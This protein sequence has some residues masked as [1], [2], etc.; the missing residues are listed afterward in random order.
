MYKSFYSPNANIKELM[1]N[2]KAS[3]KA[4][5]NIKCFILFPLDIEQTGCQFVE[6]CRHWI[7]LVC[8]DILSGFDGVSLVSVIF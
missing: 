4:I 2:I 6:R 8:Q 7:D 3:I 1:K 5:Y